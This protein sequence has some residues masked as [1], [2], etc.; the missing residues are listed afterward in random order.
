MSRILK[1]SRLPWDRRRKFST[2]PG[3]VH[4]GLAFVQANA[5]IWLSADTGITITG[6]GVSL[7]ENQGSYGSGCDVA[8]STDSERPSFNVSDANFNDQPS[9]TFDASTNEHLSNGTGLPSAPDD[10]TLFVVARCVGDPGSTTTAGMFRLSASSSTQ[11]VT[12]ADGNIY[13]TFL[14]TGGTGDR[15]DPTDDLEN[16]FYYYEVRGGTT[17]DLDINTTNLYS[18]GGNYIPTWNDPFLVGSTR[19]ADRPFDGDIAEYIFIPLEV[20]GDDKENVRDYLDQ[21]YFAGAM[22]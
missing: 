12:F 17:N 4:P 16:A 5:G 2:P 8:Q 9:I 20:L 15:G 10:G 18:V 3:S 22:P 7:W 14:A 21:K 6:S 13:S 19:V 11:L 1:R